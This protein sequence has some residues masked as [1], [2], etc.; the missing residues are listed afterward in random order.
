MMTPLAPQDAAATPAV[1]EGL[2]PQVLE[3]WETFFD[4]A[5]PTDTLGNKHYQPEHIRFFKAV[6]QLLSRGKSL[7][8]IGALLL[9][10]E[11]PQPNPTPVSQ[12]LVADTPEA[13]TPPLQQ[14]MTTVFPVIPTV[15]ETTTAAPT[16]EVPRP[17]EV[18]SLGQRFVQEAAPST[19]LPPVSY[20]ATELPSIRPTSAEQETLQQLFQQLSQERDNLRERL[21]ESE[22]LNT[23]LYN[24]NEMF[25]RKVRDL[26]ES[27]L[28]LKEKS[29]EGEVM[30]L[31]E[32]K[33][34]LQRE[35]IDV[36]RHREVA[37]RSLADVARQLQQTRHEYQD[38]CNRLDTLRSSRIPQESFYGVWQEEAALQEVVYDQIGLN[39]ETSRTRQVAIEHNAYMQQFGA[40]LMF[41]THYQYETNQLWQRRETVVLSWIN[42]TQLEGPI[43]V[44]Y[45]LEGKPVARAVYTATY[46]R[47]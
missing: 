9:G 10:P 34:K 1:I 19:D 29:K 36:R 35:L 4:I 7:D 26:T 20:E 23:H 11:S 30:K 2:A 18:V 39:M 40:S 44:E 24:T 45:L 21:L 42:D 13:A 17:P 12:P 43:F 41:T 16:A 32:D 37:E 14:S 15:A 22:K 28:R 8:E 31:L 27:I 25:R 46:S 47:A 38:I 3:S 33:A 6:D 5:V